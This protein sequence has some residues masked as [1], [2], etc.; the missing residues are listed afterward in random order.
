MTYICIEI[1][2]RIYNN[3]Y[4]PWIYLQNF[5]SGPKHLCSENTQCVE[6]AQC[7]SMGNKNGN[8][9]EM[10]KTCK[11]MEGYIE[12]NSSCSGKYLTEY[13]LYNNAAL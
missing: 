2:K 1:H 13:E 7:I 10:E 5:I 11:C 4:S 3:H 8:G 9:Q 12:L 6:G